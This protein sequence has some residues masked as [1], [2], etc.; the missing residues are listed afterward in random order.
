MLLGLAW[1]N[2][3]RQPHRTALSL[4]SISFAAATTV[5]LLALQ[6]GAYGTIKAN[7]LRLLDGFAQIQP[8]HYSDDPS[9]RKTIADPNALL[10]RLDE[11]PKITAS[12][13]RATTY[14]ILSK[15]TKSYGGA[16]FGVDAARE[17]ALSSL[18][19]SIVKGRYLVPDDR[20][21]VVIGAA[22]ARNLGIDVGGQL[23][24]LGGAS[25]GSVAADVLRVVG[26]FA[27]GVPQLDRQIVEI[28]L[29]RFQ[30]DFALDDHSNLI[31]V[32]GRSLDDV[33]ASLPELRRLVRPQGL[34]VRD[35]TELEPS[36]HDAI[37]LD[38]SI[39]L[40]WYVS[41]V[42][43]VVF[44]ILNTLLMSVLERTREFGMLMAV[45]MR[46]GQVGRMIW[47]ELF[48]LAGIGTALGIALGSAITV[49]TAWHGVPFSGAEALFSQWH[50]PAT[51]VPRLNVTSALVGPLAIAVAIAVAGV[52]PY[53]HVRRLEPVTAMR[54]A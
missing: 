43:V 9:L 5:F 44:I 50:M 13:P 42:L 38:I 32:A 8:P 45:G 11:L 23:T 47:L 28:P 20:D 17:R 46:A 36:L 21:A 4:A 53:V 15:G 24:L 7:A 25:D 18:G 51:L 14:A 12:A 6:Q 33:Q 10:A 41:V 16:V 22:L 30:A 19:S 1:R 37:L 2:I 48:F 3:W 27:T 34:Q 52:V 54:A 31:A 40:L 39:S 49:W 26:I 35:W 29:S